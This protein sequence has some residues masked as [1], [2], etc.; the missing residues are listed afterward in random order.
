MNANSVSAGHEAMADLKLP[1]P[2]EGR[3][4]A[5]WLLRSIQQGPFSFQEL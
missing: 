4:A 3:E 2:Q 5:T 1:P